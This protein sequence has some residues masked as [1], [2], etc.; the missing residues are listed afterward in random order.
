M[1]TGR[2]LSQTPGLCT[3][4]RVTGDD[5]QDHECIG[6]MATPELAQAIC[7]AVNAHGRPLP[8][9]ESSR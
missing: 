1:R 6:M 5:W 4:Y 8:V 9:T 2:S 7:E 3:L